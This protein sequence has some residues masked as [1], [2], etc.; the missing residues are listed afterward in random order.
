MMQES[1]S[2]QKYNINKTENKN[3]ILNA[4]LHQLLRTQATVLLI[5]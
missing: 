3:V 4:A 1:K 5:K 2:I